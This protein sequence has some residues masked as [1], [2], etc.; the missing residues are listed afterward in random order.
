MINRRFLNG[1]KILVIEPE[2]QTKNFF[3]KCLKAEG[4]CTIDAE[5]GLVGFQQAQQELPDLIISE[6]SLPKLDGY[7]VLTMLRQNPSTAMIPLIF[8]TTKEARYEIRKGM[9]LGA[10]DYLTKPCTVEEL[11]NAIAAC[12]EK[13]TIL[14]KCYAACEIHQFQPFTK[15]LLADILEPAI[16]KS[17]FPSN[18]LLDEVF[19]FIEENYY[20]QITLSDVALKVGY[21]STYLTNLVRRQTGQTVQNWIIE[22]RMTA[23]RTLLL[24]TDETVE[25]ISLKIGYQNVAHFFR[26]FRQHHKTTPHAWRREH[27]NQP[28]QRQKEGIA[29]FSKG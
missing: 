27:R 25:T 26:Q 21:S 22:Y 14:K 18:S 17:T 3:L 13:R 15:P 8:V 23:A 29:T 20:Q 2:V 1:K 12:L 16:L 11:L 24:K 10:D 4:F 19:S 28:D 5:N 6:I 7:S 9:E